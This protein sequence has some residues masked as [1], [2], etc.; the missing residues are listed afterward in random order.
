MHALRQVRSDLYRF[1]F[2]QSW[3]QLSPEAQQLLIYIGRTVV[4]TVSW[5][6]LEALGI[7]SSDEAL[8]AALMQLV[9][10]SLLEVSHHVGRPGQVGH[11]RYGMHQLTRQFVMSDLPGSWRGFGT[12]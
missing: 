12:S 9:A 2:E 7:A 3:R 10:Y 1:I 4:T 5:E 6:E 8:L 11:T